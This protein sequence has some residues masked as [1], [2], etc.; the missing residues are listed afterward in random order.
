MPTDRDA[1]VELAKHS[2]MDAVHQITHYL[3]MPTQDA[4]KQVMLTLAARD[5]EA[6]QPHPMFGSWG[7]LVRTKLVP[8][9]EAIVSLR[10]YFTELVGEHEGEYDGWEAEVQPAHKVSSDGQE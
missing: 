10:K 9:E 5:F 2:R 8:V 7:V 6:E 1:L 3:Y 4:A